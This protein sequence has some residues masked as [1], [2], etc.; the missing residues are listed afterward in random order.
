MITLKTITTIELSN[1]CNLQC[2][3]CVNRLMMKSGVRDIGI[4]SDETFERCLYWLEILCKH[5]TQ[6]EV[7]LN[8][9]GESC[10][11]PKL[12]ERIR[13]VKDIAGNRKVAMCTNGVNMTVDL[14]GKIRDAGIDQI[15]LSPHSPYHARKAVVVMHQ[16]GLR[17]IVNMGSITC[18]HNWAGQLEPEN[19][20]E[21]LYSIKCDPLIE[22]RGYVQKEGNVTPCCYDFRNLGVFGTVYDKDLLQKGMRPY[23]LC[24]RCHQVIPDEILKGAA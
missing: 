22:G 8:G 19:S 7:N 12:P 23:E 13:A 4:M 2:R 10:L 15:D 24:K 20:I 5:G 21:V 17:G 14:A 16:A 6:K 3:Y 18:S 9:N 11:D 1:A